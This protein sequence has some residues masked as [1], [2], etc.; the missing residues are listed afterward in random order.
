MEPK[1][2]WYLSHEDNS[3]SYEDDVGPDEEDDW[4]VR[5][6]LQDEESRCKR[7]AA[8]PTYR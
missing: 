4:S 8:K 3:H 5:G 1:L 2:Q 7:H 6:N